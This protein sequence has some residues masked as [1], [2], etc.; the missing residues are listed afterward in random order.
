MTSAC[1]SMIVFK[2]CVLPYSLWAGVVWTSATGLTQGSGQR[3]V[4]ASACALECM[5]CR[6]LRRVH[7][8]SERLNA[9]GGRATGRGGLAA[10]SEVAG[11][12]LG[13]CGCALLGALLALRGLRPVTFRVDRSEAPRLAA[14]GS[15]SPSPRRFGRFACAGEVRSGARTP[16]AAT[17]QRAASCKSAARAGEAFWHGAARGSRLWAYKMQLVGPADA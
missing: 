9:V 8:H 15:P 14:L 2:W 6:H 1:F 5:R 4:F 7:D 12:S 3:S 16:E 10:A 13:F 17:R 11:I